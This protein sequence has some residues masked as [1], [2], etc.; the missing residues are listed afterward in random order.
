MTHH[1]V[2]PG[3]SWLCPC[4]AT[5]PDV[6]CRAVG[7]RGTVTAG[8]RAASPIHRSRPHVRALV[9]GSG[10]LLRRRRDVPGLR[11]R[12]R[13]RPPRPD[14]AG[15]TTSPGSASPACGSTRSTRR[16][17]RDDG[18]DVTDFYARRPA[19][20]H[21]RRLRR[22]DAPGRQ[23]RHPGSCST[24]SSTTPPTSTR[25]SSRRAARPQLAVPRLV[26]L[27]RRRSRPTAARAWSSP[28]SR[29]RPGPSTSTAGAWYYHR[30][31]DFQPDLNLAN[32]RGARGDQEDHGLLAA[33]RRVAASAST[34]RRS[35]SS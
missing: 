23:P 13:R 7:C 33:A 14:R 29:T 28:A 22:A 30:F 4:G 27:V 12:R 24:S 20:R 35:S 10:H 34:P 9:Q 3:T 25:G 16:P 2:T 21:P 32:P 8:A 31:Y 15:W 19:A 17:N 11:R 1:G 26:R 5:D 18:Y 6:G